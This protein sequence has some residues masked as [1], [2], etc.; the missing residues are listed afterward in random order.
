MRFQHTLIVNNSNFT[1]N[2]DEMIHEVEQHGI[3]IDEII[4]EEELANIEHDTQTDNFIDVIGLEGATPAVTNLLINQIIAE[5]GEAGMPSLADG[6]ERDGE[7][8][9]FVYTINDEHVVVVPHSHY[10][11]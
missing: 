4:Q 1:L 9:G 5:G 3:P 6:Y 2:D 7:D 8:F 11:Y 10:R